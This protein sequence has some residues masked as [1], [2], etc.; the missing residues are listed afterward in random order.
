[1]LQL[2]AADDPAIGDERGRDRARRDRGIA[3]R[4]RRGGRRHR[5]SAAHRQR[6]GDAVARGARRRDRAPARRWPPPAF[7]A[8]AP[9]IDVYPAALR[10]RLLPLAFE[11]MIEGGQAAAAARLLAHQPADDPTLALARGMLRAANGDTDGALAIYDSAGQRA[12]PAAARQRG[13]SRGRTAAGGRTHR[14]G[15]C[16][17]RA[18]PAALR[19]ARRPA[20][21]GAARAGRRPARAGGRSGGAALAMLHETEKLFPDDARGGACQAE[22]HLCPAA[23]GQGIGPAGAAGAGGDWSR[24][25]PTCCRIGP[26]G[27]A[28]EERLA[29]RL[30]AARPAASARH[31]CWRN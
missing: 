31:R 6:R 12:G 13:G 24:R 19:L 18:G 5:G 7:A 28:L 30:V 8:T 1:M 9:L 15:A 20:R 4:P 14:R 2:A 26:A 23:A 16:G 25:M 17:G 22:S 3:R 27:E 10:E 29:D 21:T 11:T